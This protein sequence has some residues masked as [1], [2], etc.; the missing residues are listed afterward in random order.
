MDLTNI[1]QQLHEK[2]EDLEHTRKAQTF[3]IQQ[4]FNTGR[5][6]GQQDRQKI[7]TKLN[8]LKHNKLAI[9]FY[10][11]ALFTILMATQSMIK[12]SVAFI[13]VIGLIICGE[14]TIRNK[15]KSLNDK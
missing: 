15:S 9:V 14:L 1:K 12:F 13:V 7:A 11:A 2:V 10:V 8:N 5:S 3:Y 4:Q 6:K